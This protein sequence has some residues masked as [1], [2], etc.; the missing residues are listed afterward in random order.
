MESPIVV[1]TSNFAA[2]EKGRENKWK[3]SRSH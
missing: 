1:F 2:Y 3:S